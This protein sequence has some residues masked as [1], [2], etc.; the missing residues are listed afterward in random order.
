MAINWTEAQIAEVVSKVLAQ[1][2]SPAQSSDKDWDSTQYHG[3]KLIGVYNTMEEAIAAAEAGYKAIRAMSVAQREKLITTELSVN[4]ERVKTI[5][6]ASLTIYFAESGEAV[7]DI[8]EKYNTTVDAVMREN[9]ITEPHI[10]EKCRLL[11]PK[12]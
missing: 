11:I 10:K 3:R 1:V 8:A 9:H 4:K 5:K 12:M 6:T 2:Q 7:W